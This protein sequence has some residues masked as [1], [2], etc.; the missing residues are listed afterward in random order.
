MKVYRVYTDT[1][2]FISLHIYMRQAEYSAAKYLKSH[3]E[4]QNVT[5]CYVVIERYDMFRETRDD[6]IG[7][8]YDYEQAMKLANV[9]KKYHPKP[10]DSRVIVR[11][12]YDEGFVEIPVWERG[13]SYKE[14]FYQWCMETGKWKIAKSGYV[15]NKINV[16]PYNAIPKGKYPN[17]SP[18]YDIHKT[19]RA[20]KKLIM[21]TDLSN[22][23][24]IEWVTYHSD[25]EKQKRTGRIW[26]GGRCIHHY[27]KEQ[28]LEK[29]DEMYEKEKNPYKPDEFDYLLV[30]S[31]DG[32][33]IETYNGR[34]HKGSPV[35]KFVEKSLAEGCH[36]EQFHGTLWEVEWFRE[37]NLQESYR[38]R[39]DRRGNLY[40]RTLDEAI[41][42]VKRICESE[43]DKYVA[44][45]TVRWGGNI[46]HEVIKPAKEYDLKN[47]PFYWLSR[48]K[49]RYK[50]ADDPA[51]TR[52]NHI[53]ALKQILEEDIKTV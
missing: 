18:E 38:D 45:C 32:K 12:M 47:E 10:F 48:E 53:N 31:E 24:D 9:A 27:T 1:K 43:T 16:W 37:E 20:L 34:T 29:L 17:I 41:A 4:K 49:K 42:E 2:Q 30:V 23:D 46:V 26:L 7:V 35:G 6:I 40:F 33:I 21:T 51:K 36:V 13:Y 44:I 52:Q 50:V 19:Y 15:C 28:A 8:F 25:Y 14:K 3:I 5:K 22:V 39:F 11:M